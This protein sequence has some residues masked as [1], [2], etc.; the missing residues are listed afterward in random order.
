MHENEADT[1]VAVL[2]RIELSRFPAWS[3]AF[4]G[5]RKDFRYFEIVEDTIEPKFDHRYFAIID[6][7]GQARA[8]A[9]FFIVDQD[10]LQGAGPHITRAVEAVRKRAADHG[11]GRLGAGDRGHHDGHRHGR[12]GLLVGVQARAEEG[13][14]LAERGKA[15]EHTDKSYG[16]ID[17]KH[18]E[19]TTRTPSIRPLAHRLCPKAMRA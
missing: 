11:A 1:Q 3:S 15:G 7:G 9:P 12:V 8:F 6:G 5:E 4:A 14:R 13:D 2:S 19:W 10:I 18:F 17:R 16:S